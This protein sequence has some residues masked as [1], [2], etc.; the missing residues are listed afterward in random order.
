M[1]TTDDTRNDS[2]SCL[3]ISRIRPH[4]KHT[5]K[6]TGCV[7]RVESGEGAVL[8]SGCRL[9]IDFLLGGRSLLSTIFSYIPARLT[10][11][12]SSRLCHECTGQFK[13][14]ASRDSCVCLSVVKPMMACWSFSKTEVRCAVRKKIR[15]RH[16]FRSLLPNE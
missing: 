13:Y 14:R 11:R 15:R 9:R 6:H 4:P 3:Q 16:R 12:R 1:M 5:H 2:T 8:G 10:G 7:R